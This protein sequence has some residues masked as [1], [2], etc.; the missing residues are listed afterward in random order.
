MADSTET[1]NN[2][3]HLSIADALAHEILN[4]LWVPGTNKKLEQIQDQ[5][6]ISRTVAR[7]ATRLLASLRCVQFQ[8]GTGVIACAPE[9]WDDLNTR[10]IS[11]KLRSPY[12]HDELRD[13]TELR[14][15]VEPAAAAGCASRGSIESRTR[16]A[17][18][19]HEL[20]K[21]A[22][23]DR[24]QDF[25]ALDIEFHASLLEN[26]GNPIFAELS[27]T[28]ATVLRGRVEINLYPQH[29]EESALLAH[30]K[31]AQAVLTGDAQGAYDAMHDIVSEV[32]TA[33]GLSAM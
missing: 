2:P 17:V 18:V 9:D 8:R 31:V 16:I 28:V 7:E 5:Y 29:P 6:E 21:A 22:R 1:Q 4:D 26:C 25:H 24:L 20:I 30:E 33:L 32:N 12:R 15:V 11:W 10:V 3:L 27:S 14:L 19:G 13:L 23:E